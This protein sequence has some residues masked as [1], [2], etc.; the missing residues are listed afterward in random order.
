MPDAVMLGIDM[1]SSSVKVCAYGCDGVL[2]ARSTQ[3]WALSQPQ[4]GHVEMDTELMW[5]QTVRAIKDVISSSGDTVLSI[6]ISAACPSIV[7]L[8][9]K[10]QAIRPAILYLDNRSNPQVRQYT[11][12]HGSQAHFVRSGNRPGTSTSW[13]S[14]VA[15]VREHEPQLWQ[16]VKTVTLQ[17]GF[18]TT[19]LTG[20]PV[21]DWTQASYSGGFRIDRP[22]QGWDEAL[23][24]CWGIEKSRLAPVGWSCLCA[25]TLTDAAMQALGIRSRIPVAYGCAD[26]A[27]S[28]FALGMRDHG[29]VFESS[30][31]SGVIS[32]CLERPDFDDTFM[33]RCHVF[34]HRWLAHGAMSTLGGAFAWLLTIW[35]D[36]ASIEALEQLAASA[37]PGANGLVFL[38]YLAGERSPIWDPDASALWAG[39]LMSHTRADMARA[40]FEGTAFGLKQIFERG[41]KIWNIQPDFLLGVGGG[42]RSTLW[43]QI[44]NDVLG[45]RYDCAAQADTAAM[46]AALVGAIAAGI[47]TGTD[48]STIPFAPLPTAGVYPEQRQAGTIAKRYDHAFQAYSKLY[49]A[50][51]EV[52]H[53][54]AGT[55]R[56]AQKQ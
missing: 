29:Q 20:Q 22:E 10:Q 44:K 42:A 9:D 30:G 54:L 6:G 25:G 56:A 18:L 49:G 35:P 53:M 33:N 46:G 19:R 55:A 50:T 1:G 3:V 7:F 13:L 38:P 15:W 28:A 21:I 11:Q 34:P 4:R 36:L 27:A 14:S 41:K 32:F 12:K 47:F 37:P 48:D 31:T 2:R 26:T 40:V 17:S 45:V 16:R 52:M 8:D 24:D 51:R 43:R 23:L 5:Q 39:L